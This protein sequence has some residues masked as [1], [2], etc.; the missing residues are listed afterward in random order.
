MA[1]AVQGRESAILEDLR[2]LACA[3]DPDFD[4]LGAEYA[5]FYSASAATAF[6]HPLWLDA[7]YTRLAPARG[8]EK[9]IVT[10]RDGRKLVCVV[11]L[12]RRRKSGV[13]L[14]ETAD[15]GVSDYASPVAAPGWTPPAGLAEEIAG[16]LP[17]HDILRIRPIREEAVDLWNGLL[18]G[19][20]G[21]LDF[22]SHATALTGS[23]A[24][25]R[26]GAL[27]PSFARQ[28]DR[29]KKK[30]ART[31]KAELRLL[32][33]PEEITVAIAAIASLRAG[34]FAGDLI[35]QD[36]VCDFY[37]DIAVRGAAA[38]F[39]RTYA[40]LLDGEPIGHTFGLTAAGRF[41]YLLI[42]CDYEKHGR[43]SPG[44]LLYDG[45]IEDWMRDGGTVFDFTIGDEPFKKDFGTLPTAMFELRDVPTWRGRLAGAAFEAREQFRKLRRGTAT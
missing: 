33:E 20:V 8:A 27:D 19:A 44:L 43:H 40:L 5:A 23:F 7:L 14:V 34:R 31:G 42:G 30:F 32:A 4:F 26:A 1:K 41:D 45:M 39:A 10:V 37:T 15:L 28:L 24:A 3:I 13:T 6:Q 16:L 38:N 22:A 21:K 29:K 35:Q 11:P 36:F 12:L 18:G 9:L 25:W 17:P 2:P